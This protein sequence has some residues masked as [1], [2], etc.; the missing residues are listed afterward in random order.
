M[1]EMTVNY[2]LHGV[3]GIWTKLPQEV[4]EVGI[5]RDGQIY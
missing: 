5:L 1:V 3:V 2:I 4:V